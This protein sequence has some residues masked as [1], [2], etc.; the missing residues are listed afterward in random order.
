MMKRLA[1]LCLCIYRLVVSQNTNDGWDAYHHNRNISIAEIPGC[2]AI[3][4]LKGSP[5]SSLLLQ[6]LSSDHI[7]N[8]IVIGDVHGEYDGLLENLYAANITKDRNVCEWNNVT[9]NNLFIQIGDV[10]DRGLRSH[11]SYFCLKHLQDTASNSNKVIRILGN[12]CIW[13]LEGSFH[14]KH[15]NESMEHANAVVSDMKKS[16]LQGKLQVAYSTYHN[17]IPLL[18]THAGLRNDMITY[19]NLTDVDHITEY[20]NS[21]LLEVVN[22]CKNS[23][24]LFTHELFQ[25][26]KER[27]GRNIGGCTWTDFDVF[28]KQDTIPKFHQI[29]GHSIHDRIRVSR[30]LNAIDVDL[31]MT[32]SKKRGFLKIDNNGK[33]LAYEK[34]KN[35]KWYYRDL[36]KAICE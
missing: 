3:S 36:S 17:G 8:I 25:A 7:D 33:F 13:W 20:I 14:M 22:K 26:G 24:C 5:S 6:S 10:V 31:G 9:R 18:F 19:I 32:H 30:Y 11:D 16:I 28:M 35:K 34:N 2:R 21:R 23:N 29:V 27:G 4:R 12:H 15:V 1:L